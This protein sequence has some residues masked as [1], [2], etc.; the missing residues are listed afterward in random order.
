MA[1][2]I[3]L[4]VMAAIGALGWLGGQSGVAHALAKAAAITATE[5]RT[6]EE[7]HA[8]AQRAGLFFAAGIAA[9]IL[10]ATCAALA[11]GF[12]LQMGYGDPLHRAL[13]PGLE[14]AKGIALAGGVG[15]VVL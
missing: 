8:H 2:L 15:A 11:I 3:E 7:I 1:L 9:L 14:F 5:V 6:A 4:L 13:W 10:P 12:A